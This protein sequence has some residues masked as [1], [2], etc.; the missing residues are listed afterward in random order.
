MQSG[1]NHLQELRHSLDLAR[2]RAM[3]AGQR[4][5][6]ARRGFAA[7]L[8]GAETPLTPSARSLAAPAIALLRERY[9]RDHI[10]HCAALSDLAEAQMAVSDATRAGDPPD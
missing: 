10:R 8:P 5:E 9:R 7:A 4:A 3:A 2:A 1:H 6:A